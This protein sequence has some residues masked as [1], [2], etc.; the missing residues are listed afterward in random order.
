VRTTSAK[1]AGQTATLPRLDFVDLR[2]VL[3]VAA[4]KSLTRGAELSA[5]SLAAASMRVKNV[6]DAVGTPLFYRGKRG[7]SPTPAGEAFLRHAQAIFRQLD[8]LSAELAQYA[9]GV[10]GHVRLFANTTATTDFLPKVLPAFLAAHPHVDVDLR[11]LASAGI[12]R[13]LQE[14]AADIG[15]VSGHVGAEGLESFP[16]YVDRMVLVTPADHPLA[17]RAS[18]AFAEALGHDFVGRNPESALHSF[19][20][21]VVTSYGRRLKSRIQVGSFEEM[22]RLIEQGIGI[23][24]V[25]LS[26][27]QR[28]DAGRRIRVVRIEDEW[29][30]QPLK[31]CVRDLERLPDF[32]RELVDFLVA[33]AAGASSSG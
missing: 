4:A 20:A 29:S 26:S 18:I 1:P 24:V 12:V 25:P 2:L 11:E 13:A 7:I 16:Y 31:I 32:A 14:G 23:G 21:D 28:Q 9:K 30:V 33:D 17:G 6:E 19:I 22:C 3:N 8:A 5:L 27:V 10:K 15:I